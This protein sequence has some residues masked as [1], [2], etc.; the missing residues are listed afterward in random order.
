MGLVDH[1]LERVYASSSAIQVRLSSAKE[2]TSQH[3]SGATDGGGGERTHV[4]G[5]GSDATAMRC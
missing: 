5:A 4:E 1:D 3:S 2:G